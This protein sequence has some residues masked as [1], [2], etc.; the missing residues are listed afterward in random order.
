MK[1]RRKTGGLIYYATNFQK[2]V[3]VTDE[4]PK[5][6]EKIA[7]I[8]DFEGTPGIKLSSLNYTN[9][10]Y[11]FFS[12]Y[13]PEFMYEEI[14]KFTNI[15]ATLSK[16]FKNKQWNEC[17]AQEIKDL[18]ALFFLFELIKKNN[19][20]DYWTDD[21]LLHVS[22]VEKI[23]SED[24]FFSF[25]KLLSFYDKSKKLELEKENDPFYK[26][27]FLINHIREAC[28]NIYIPE[29]NLILQE[30]LL[31]YAGITKIDSFDTRKQRGKNEI[32]IAVL[33]EATSGYVWNILL[34]EGNKLFEKKQL[35]NII[36]GL[37]YKGY[38]LYMDSIFVSPNIL[39]DLKTRHF[40]A[41][42]MISV[43]RLK[44]PTEIKNE[45]DAIDKPGGCGFFKNKDL[46]VAVWNHYQRKVFGI[47]N[48]HDCD[49]MTIKKSRKIGYFSKV[50]YKIYE[51][52]APRLIN[53]IIEN[54]KGNDYLSKIINY[55]SLDYNSWKW[56]YRVL[57]YF[58]EI[59]MMNSYLVYVKALKQKHLTP[60]SNL[61]YRVEIIK[62]LCKWSEKI[63]NPNRFEKENIIEKVENNFKENEEK[64]EELVFDDIILTN[65]CKLVYIGVGF[66]DYCRKKRHKLKKTLFWCKECQYGLCV[67]CYDQHKI[68]QIFKRM[69]TLD[70][71]YNKNLFD[72]LIFNQNLQATETISDVNKNGFMKRFRRSKKQL[73]VLR[74]TKHDNKPNQENHEKEEGVPM[75]V[76]NENNKQ[77]G[78]IDKPINPLKRKRKPYK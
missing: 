29:K 21:P 60:I 10:P 71:I 35:L 66:C 36:N 51:Y 50:Q 63:N 40:G 27:K 4:N 22:S 30:V 76:D 15:S 2:W 26:C 74:K 25:K 11:D 24:R 55:F 70:P 1:T 13:V 39:V 28:S 16:Y 3:K 77:D 37:E 61:E 12:Q 38:I 9:N 73:N 23:M 20:A 54:L 69:K 65:N 57:H 31:N 58:L 42:G 59:S 18:F 8:K 56:Y 62:S 64:H 43:K 5:T 7:P 49:I 41:C 45:I 47:S 48:F 17:N 72:L 32:N 68:D 67:K 19:L 52:E 14:A 75:A 53:E 46:T 78:P 33:R 6:D 34:N 44:P